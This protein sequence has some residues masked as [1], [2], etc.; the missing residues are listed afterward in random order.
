VQGNYADDLLERMVNPYLADTIAR[1]GRDPV[2]KLGLNDRIFGTMQIVLAAG[3]EPVNMA[4]AAAAGITVLLADANM[5]NVPEN[6]RVSDWRKISIQQ[7]EKILLW[8]WEQQQ[9]KYSKELIRL[10]QDA[11]SRFADFVES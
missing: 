6:L 8:I 3:I 4:L 11:R 10:V 2:R 1:A 9:S 7:I 5:Y